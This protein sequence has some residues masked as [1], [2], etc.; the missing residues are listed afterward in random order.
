MI[1]HFSV[2]NDISFAIE[3]ALRSLIGSLAGFLYDYIVELFNVFMYIARAEILDNAYVKLVYTRVGMILGLFMLFKLSFTLIQS[4]IN[5]DKFT[6]KKNGFAAVITRIIIAIV[7]LGVTPSIFRFALNFQSVIVG[8]SGDNNNVLYKIVVNNDVIEADTKTFGNRLATDLF[9][10]FFREKTD[11]HMPSEVQTICD[12]DANCVF[13]VIGYNTLKR[14]AYDGKIKFKDLVPYLSIRDNGYY[15][16]DWDIIL[17]VGVGVAILWILINYCISIATRVIQIAYLQIISPIPILSY[18]SDPD[19]A[20]KRWLK[21][22]STTYLELFLRL[23]IIY[24]IVTVCNAVLETINNS[25]SDFFISSGLQEGTTQYTLVK[26]FIILGLLMF[27]KRVPELIKDLFPGDGKFD[28]G[29]KSP[30]KLFGEIPGINTAYGVAKGA[31]TF[32][33]GALAGGAVGLIGGRGF[34]G[35]VS[36]LFGGLTKGGISGAKGTKLSDI[37]ANRASMNKQQRINAA[38]GSTW[39]GRFAENLFDKLGLENSVEGLDRMIHNIDL[40]NRRIDDDIQLNDLDPIRVQTQRNDAVLNARK[41]IVSEIDSQLLREDNNEAIAVSTR[42]YRDLLNSAVERYNRSGSDVDLRALE[43]AR[44]DYYDQLEVSRAQYFNAHRENN[45]TI[46]R[47]MQVVRDQS[48]QEVY[49]WGDLTRVRNEARTAN[50]NMS[51]DI[52]RLDYEKEELNRTKEAN[53]RQKDTLERRKIVSQ[54]DIDANKNKQ[55]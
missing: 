50:A 29:I 5:P 19:G 15:V 18:I 54:A 35:R 2:F 31:A 24:F 4:L 3:Q 47:N 36:G 34:F 14:D 16:Y 32:G 11:V 6:D 55:H 49:L 46:A 26:L 52:A 48:G 30:K 41:A 44:T 20:F 13:K 38:N 12:L 27:G 23:G 53:N 10:S 21:Q 37:I 22:C 43:R 17:S 51:A 39:A 40:E 9:F 42:H 28:L 7:L 33:A 45:A 1:F 8:S 25:E